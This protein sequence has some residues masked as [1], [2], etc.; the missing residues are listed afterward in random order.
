MKKQNNY[1]FWQMF[2][3]CLGLFFVALDISLEQSLQIYTL[4]ALFGSLIF[5]FLQINDIEK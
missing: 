2:F 3:L 5:V 4:T 1:F